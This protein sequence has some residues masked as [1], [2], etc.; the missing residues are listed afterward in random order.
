M[1]ER[2]MNF[3]EELFC[4]PKGKA[5]WYCIDCTARLCESC[6]TKTL[7]HR[8]NKTGR[9]DLPHERAKY[10]IVQKFKQI[11]SP[12]DSPD[13]LQRLFDEDEQSTWF[14]LTE[15][16]SNVYALKAHSTYSDLM[17]QSQQWAQTARFPH[18]VSFIGQTGA[19]KST[20]VKM[21]IASCEDRATTMGFPS[22]VVG[23]PKND[24]LPTS[25]D[26]HLYADPAT[27]RHWK[28]KLYADCEGLDAGEVVPKSVQAK[29]TT[30]QEV[31]RLATK[32][33]SS[34]RV[35]SLH[36][37]NTAKTCTRNFAVTDLY[38]RL[39]YTFSDVVVFVLRNAKSFQQTALQRLL[40]WGS[41]SLEKSVG[42]PILPHAIIAVNA[43]EISMPND[44]WNVEYAT[45]Q[46]LGSVK[47][48]LESVPEFRD[49][50]ETW[51]KHGK[52][53][54]QVLDLIKCYYSS[55]SVIRIPFKGRYGLM[56]G[57]VTKLRTKIGELCEESYFT[58]RKARMLSNAEELD[59]YVQAGFDHFSQELEKPFNFVK[60]AIDNNPIP[61]D[62][63]GHIVQLAI[64][65]QPYFPNNAEGA[66]ELFSRLSSMVASCIFLN[67]VLNLKGLAHITLP[68]YGQLLESALADFCSL[69][70]PCEFENSRGRCV[71]VSSRHGPKGH[72]N[73]SGKIIG[74][75]KYKSDFAP[76]VYNTTWT[77]NIFS[78]VANLD[79]EHLRLVSPTHNTTDKDIAFKLHR[80]RISKFYGLMESATKFTS[81]G[82]CLCCLMNMPKYPLPCG[83]VLCLQC[84][85]SH[86]RDYQGVVRTLESCPL[87]SDEKP[88]SIP[89]HIDFKPPFAG[90]RILSLD[91]G[92]IRG[93]V[94]LETLR[95]IQE[96]LGVEIPITQFFDLIVG[97]STGGIIAL[98][99]GEKNWPLDKCISH[100]L[101]LCDRAFTPRELHRVPGMHRVTS[102]SHGSLYK[103]RPLVAAL[104]EEFGSDLLFGGVRDSVSRDSTK[105]AVTSTDE[106][107]K[108]AIIFANYR[109]SGN[110]TPSWE[111][112]Q[113]S[114]PSLEMKTWE[115]AVATSAAPSYFKP[116]YHEPAGRFYLD[117]ALYN[118]NPV[119][120][121]HS[122][123]QILWPD[124]SS[125][126]PDI[127][128]SI[129]TGQ[130]EEEVKN[131]TRATAAEGRD[132]D[133]EVKKKRKSTSRIRRWHQIFSVML[134][135]I[136]SILNAE[137]AW[138]EF[139]AM[140]DLDSENTK[141]ERYIRINPNLGD[142]VP[143]LDEKKQLHKLREDAKKAL[144][145]PGMRAEIE[146]TSYR[147]IA[148]LFYYQR[149]T[150]PL[151]GHDNSVSCSG[152]IRCR[153]TDRPEEKSIYIRALG[154][155]FSQ[156]VDQRP[157]FEIKEDE[158]SEEIKKLYIDSQVI[159][160]MSKRA[161]FNIEYPLKVPTMTSSVSITLRLGHIHNQAGSYPISGFPRTIM[162][163]ES[164]KMSKPKPASQRRRNSLPSLVPDPV[165]EPQPK[166]ATTWG[167]AP[168]KRGQS[169]EEKEPSLEAILHS[170]R[171]SQQHLSEAFH[172]PAERRM[173]AESPLQ[174]SSSLPRRAKRASEPDPEVLRKLRHTKDPSSPNEALSGQG[175]EQDIARQR[176]ISLSEDVDDNLE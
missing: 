37:A 5:D 69:Y 32:T 112:H 100:F 86:G 72:Q 139:C 24:Q 106:T 93:I 79:K 16:E 137:T 71:N 109:H 13:E 102:L 23:S 76:E 45:T 95:A 153:L 125:K 119:K 74:A 39:L 159:D 18:L 167:S 154:E 19:G 127:F 9:D 174:R 25:A 83:H 169:V 144:Q 146:R 121:A 29:K 155:F 36:W 89:W 50:V 107:G 56:D 152:A 133:A 113:P 149:K 82:T 54:G 131:K 170:L 26:V 120:V 31:K 40:E 114:N 94:E 165:L 52:R 48:C 22:P 105:V 81:H 53:I 38:P 150:P 80:G 60:V 126:A 138:S 160:Q 101:N 33:F 176:W 173:R 141:R 12:P 75:G 10:E 46:L 130:N 34:T 85:N 122:E 30:R 168:A 92:G 55:F 51:R 3:C 157:Y 49:H 15:K 91:G 73:E 35:R 164:L 104:R 172:A 78:E 44:E 63:G 17:A 43:T 20:L 135:R 143:R 111:F 171:S 118:N 62:F 142:N 97:T 27:F 151:L 161:T 4:N 28:P 128:L 108:K 166:L 59:V 68:V 156:R 87:H 14:G 66:K 77:E 140:S 136:D 1:P 158:T 61:D 57:Q 134:R 124:V 41:R 7:A 145:S 132:M 148:S 88:F 129:G 8:N 42:Q 84:V 90:V 70:L 2:E 64:L 116:F 98:A 96:S 110:N 175:E 47:D 11:L 162:V 6:W 147:L 21:L 117:G 99:L 65:M 103:T 115:A 58:K 67:C 123:R 163:E